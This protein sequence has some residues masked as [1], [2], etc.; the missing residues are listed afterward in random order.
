M[1]Y[2]DFKTGDLVEY[3]S[4]L[5]QSRI[6]ILIKK[7]EANKLYHLKNKKIYSRFSNWYIENCL[8]KLK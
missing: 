4:I 7:S 5:P 8:R 3:F 2:E 1:D 6:Y